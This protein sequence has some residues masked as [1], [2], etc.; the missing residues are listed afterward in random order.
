MRPAVSRA[1]LGSA[2]LAAV[3]TAMAEILGD[4]ISRQAEMLRDVNPEADVLMWSDML[5]PNHNAHGDYYLVEGDFTGSWKHV[6]KD[7]AIVCWYYAKREP[8]LKF[9]SDLGFSTLAGAY[10]DGDTLENPRGWLEALDQTEGATG[11][12]YTTWENKYGLLAAFGD[13]VSPRG[14]PKSRRR[15]SFPPGAN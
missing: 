1:V 7:L 6:P 10:Y 3:S 8:S 12:M 5:D 9:F 15:P 4:C 13:L 11:I 2:V 14:K